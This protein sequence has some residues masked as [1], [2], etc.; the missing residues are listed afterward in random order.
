MIRRTLWPVAGQ[1][2][3]A[4]CL[5]ALAFGLVGI[6]PLLSLSTGLVAVGMAVMS[7][8]RPYWGLVALMGLLPVASLS[9]W[10]GWR[11]TDELDV[12]LLLILGGGYAREAWLSRPYALP[13]VPAPHIGVLS[14]AVGWPVRLAWGAVLLTWAVSAWRGWVDAG[15]SAPDLLWDGYDSTGNVWRVAK[16]TVGLLLVA[17]WL[18]ALYRRSPQQAIRSLH[19]GLL[20]GLILVCGLAVWERAVYI[21]LWD[22]S[23]DYRTTAW[24][25]EMHVGGGA[26][27]V[28]LALTAPMAWWALWRARTAWQ[29]WGAATLLVVLVYVVVTTYSRG[30]AGVFVGGSV[31]LWWLWRRAP[32]ELPE[33]LAWRK[34]AQRWLVTGLVVEALCLVGAGQFAS[35]RLANTSVDVQ[36]RWAHWQSM[37]GLLSEPEDWWWGVG[38]GRLPARHSALASG[39]AMPGGVSWSREPGWQAV[40]LQ[41]PQASSEL[42]GRLALARR[43]PLAPGPQVVHLTVRAKEETRLRFRLCERHLLY[44]IRC[45]EAVGTVQ[46]GPAQVLQWPMSGPELDGYTGVARYREGMATLAVMQTN[47]T[48]E[49]WGWDIRNAENQGVL[50]HADFSD[51]FNGWFFVTTGYFRPWHADSLFMELWVERGLLGSLAHVMLVACILWQVYRRCFT[52]ETWLLPILGGLVSCSVLLCV[53][54]MTELPRLSFLAG[55]LLLVSSLW[56]G[57]LHDRS[58]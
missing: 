4:L 34:R 29:W 19:G 58:P 30:L 3:A 38:Q 45:Q 55:G 7:A 9:I 15:A 26:I 49:V 40:R 5:W 24:F 21:G 2:A 31:L 50:H 35:D 1:G 33:T 41:G 57:V 12:L 53:I 16:S 27:D 17:P 6:H 51:G 18:R 54:S 46:P 39:P 8:V 13:R 52:G 43:V 42:A 20:I 23:S 11:V 44:E 14:L 56:G 32:L 37:Y 48:V 36:S 10:S 28:Y 47:R 22:L 25:W